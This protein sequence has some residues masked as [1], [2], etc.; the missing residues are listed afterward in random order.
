[1]ELYV[2]QAMRERWCFSPTPP[3]LVDIGSVSNFPTVLGLWAP[4][5]GKSWKLAMELLSKH[6]VC[7]WARSE[8]GAQTVRLLCS[9]GQV[10]QHSKLQSPLRDCDTDPATTQIFNIAPRSSL[11]PHR[12]RAGTGC[13]LCPCVLK[14]F[15]EEQDSFLASPVVLQG[16]VRGGASS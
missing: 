13:A 12:T 14:S 6:K 8:R 2:R 5:Q 9:P 11:K 16:R 10:P 7:I 3:S 1:M 4:R 15:L